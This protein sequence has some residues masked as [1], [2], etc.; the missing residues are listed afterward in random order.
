ML[1]DFHKKVDQLCFEK[2]H[3]HL[4]K[5]IL[6]P[7][8][9]QNISINISMKMLINIFWK[10]FNNFSSSSTTCGGRRRWQHGSRPTGQPQRRRCHPTSQAVAAAH[11]GATSRRA[12]AGRDGRR[13]RMVARVCC[14]YWA[15]WA[16]N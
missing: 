2:L 13:W 8:F 12:V 16:Y 15:V 9:S 5:K 7:T 11:S 6:N 4:C 14:C 3:Q 10:K 1:Q